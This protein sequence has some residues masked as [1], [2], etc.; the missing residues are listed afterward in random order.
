MQYKGLLT[1]KRLGKQDM[2]VIP[3]EIIEVDNTVYEKLLS[4]D[5]TV[6][7]TVEFRI[8]FER[9]ADKELRGYVEI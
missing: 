1:V 2:L 4:Q 9:G 7:E 6:L 8:R 3:L 5:N